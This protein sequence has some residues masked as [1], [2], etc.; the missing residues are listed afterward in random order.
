MSYTDKQLQLATQIAYM[1]ISEEIITEYYKEYGDYPILQWL[2]S[3]S[4][5]TAN[6]IADEYMAIYDADA[7]ADSIAGIRCNS[8]QKIIDDIVNGTSECASWKFVS[9]MNE[10]SLNTKLCKCQ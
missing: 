4:D 1:K 10:K 9:V 8:A 2:L 3:N 7:D 6:N 5:N